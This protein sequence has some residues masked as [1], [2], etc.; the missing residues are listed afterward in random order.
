MSALILVINGY[1]LFT[2]KKDPYRKSWHFIYIDRLCKLAH[3]LWIS[4]YHGY[5]GTFHKDLLNQGLPETLGATSD[6]NMLVGKGD[7]VAD[8]PDPFDA[9]RDQRNHDSIHNN[10]KSKEE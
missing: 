2:Y 4:T 9:D 5:V 6:Q 7:R 1:L 10:D 8:G 3:F